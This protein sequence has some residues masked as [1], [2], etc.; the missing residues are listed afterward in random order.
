[1]FKEM[2]LDPFQKLIGYR[3]TDISLLGSALTHPSF[4]R[5]KNPPFPLKIHFQ[6]LE[7]LGDRLLSAVLGFKL[8]ELFPGQREGFLSKAYM[9]LSQSRSLVRI[10]Q[11]LQ[12]K[13]Y[14]RVEQNASAES[15]ICD[16][17]EALI[18]AIWLDSNYNIATQCILNWFG[19]IEKTVLHELKC[20]NYKGQ[21]QELVGS[22]LHDIHY[23]L[24]KEWGPE[25][26]RQFRT[27]VYLGDQL[28]AS[29][30][31]FSKQ[32]SEEKAAALAIEKFVNFVE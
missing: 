11:K 22:R 32:E 26:Q 15:I 1:M 23:K 13:N 24:E 25:H 28:L 21:L 19:D 7:F 6:R 4:Y 9:G 20:L 2:A 3:F 29:G 8:F 30:E 12:V 31:G 10:A 18:G 14:L 5:H 17:V 27:S 16:A